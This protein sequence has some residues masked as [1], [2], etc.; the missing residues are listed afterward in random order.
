MDLNDKEMNKLYSIVFYVRLTI[1]FLFIITI[2]FYQEIFQTK[3]LIALALF[4]IAI[5]FCFIPAYFSFKYKRV[6]INCLAGK[7]SREK[8][9]L[10]EGIVFTTIGIAI[11]VLG[12]YF[13]I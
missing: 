6:K 11:S 3:Y 13:L 9:A 1:I 7:F 10:R 2:L 12:I 4:I 5:F 8:I